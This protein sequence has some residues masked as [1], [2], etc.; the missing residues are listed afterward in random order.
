MKFA[1]QIG[2]AIENWCQAIVSRVDFDPDSDFD[3]G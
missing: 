2:I 1:V 3:V